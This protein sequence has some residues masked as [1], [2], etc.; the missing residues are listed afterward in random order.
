ME[1]LLIIDITKGEGWEKL[2][3]FL[4]KEIPNT[5]FPHRHKTGIR[6]RDEILLSKTKARQ[7]RRSK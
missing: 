3:L 4:N 5:E 2:C 6:T 1:D 7:R